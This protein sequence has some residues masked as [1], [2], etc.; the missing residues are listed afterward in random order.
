MAMPTAF[1]TLVSG[2]LFLAVFFFF[3]SEGI[4]W[5]FAREGHVWFLAFWEQEPQGSYFLICALSLIPPAFS[6]MPTP[7]LCSSFVPTSRNWSKP[8]SLSVGEGAGGLLSG[9]GGGLWGMQS[10]CMYPLYQSSCF[11]VSASASLPVVLG[12]SKAWATLGFCVRQTTL[13]SPWLSQTS[14]AL[15][16]LPLFQLPEFVEISNWR[17]CS[18]MV[19][20]C[21][22]IP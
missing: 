21:I 10:L 4:L 13:L 17:S 19:F 12:A 16:Q 18:P 2:S 14:S 6:T 20:D 8:P 3:F 15:R 22:D 5:S 9:W 11:H 1:L 7:A